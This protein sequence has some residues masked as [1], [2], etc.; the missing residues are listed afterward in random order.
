MNRLKKNSFACFS[1]LALMTISLGSQAATTCA[2]RVSNAP[3]FSALS[4]AMLLIRYAR[5][6]R[7]TALIGGTNATD[8]GAVESLIASRRLSL[9][10]NGDTAFDSVDALAI[11][12]SLLSFL[13]GPPLPNGCESGGQIT[14][15]VKVIGLPR[16]AGQVWLA[17]DNS[18]SLNT[19]KQTRG[20]V[21]V[22]GVASIPVGEFATALLSNGTRLVAIVESPNAEAARIEGRPTRGLSLATSR[23]DMSLVSPLTNLIDAIRT[24]G[25]NTLVG[26]ETQV[27]N[28]FGLSTGDLYASTPTAGALR[29]INL[30][31]AAYAGYQDASEVVFD[32]RGRSARIARE[33]AT[34]RIISSLPS[35]H[36][37]FAAVANT[38][39]DAQA[40][41]TE[42]GFF[43]STAEIADAI[44]SQL[45]ALPES[46]AVASLKTATTATDPYCPESDTGVSYRDLGKMIFGSD[47]YRVGLNEDKLGVNQLFAGSCTAD[48]NMDSNI[49]GGLGGWHT[50]IDYQVL[51]ATDSNDVRRAVP[52]FSVV[53]GTVVYISPANPA[54][55]T[56]NY[57]V[58][59]IRD[60]RN[61]QRIWRHLHLDRIDVALNDTVTIGC[62]IG[63]SGGTGSVRNSFPVHAHIEVQEG[64]N[65]TGSGI[66]NYQD[67]RDNVITLGFR[68]PRM[69]VDAFIEPTQT[70]CNDTPPV[71]NWRYAGSIGAD[72][73]RLIRAVGFNSRGNIYVANDLSVVSTHSPSSFGKIAADIT[74]VESDF[75]VSGYVPG[76]RTTANSGSKLILGANGARQI[77]ILDLDERKVI[78]R[79]PFAAA[80]MGRTRLTRD[81]AAFPEVATLSAAGDS[82]AIGMGGTW[83]AD[84]ASTIEMFSFPEGVA[85]SRYV[86]VAG[87]S[88]ATLYAYT[89]RVRL[90]G[91]ITLRCS[92]N[93]LLYVNDTT[94]SAYAFATLPTQASITRMAVSKNGDKVLV[95]TDNSVRQ[96]T[97][98][99]LADT[100]LGRPTVSSQID[101]GGQFQTPLYPRF[102][103][104]EQRIYVQRYQ[105]FQIYSPTG[106]LGQTIPYPAGVVGTPSTPSAVMTFNASA[107]RLLVPLSSRVLV[108]RLEP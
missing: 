95:A 49:L 84:G 42:N 44:V 18:M 89:N 40:I 26:A 70:R 94:L 38:Y 27:R 92:N 9:D 34:S 15:E 61:S 74:P 13:G 24:T 31:A 11:S 103:D 90:S 66:S 1:A 5:G 7:G 48:R 98:F 47:N 33:L 29:T 25:T 82:L 21:E 87:G 71:L 19:A 45:E 107:T 57:G 32:T 101:F 4:D 20:L 85:K 68:N 52:Q 86:T 75:G 79:I 3:S 58:V 64:A 50:G 65:V 81:R 108:Y 59:A 78:D 36:T 99:N 102:D 14:A 10:T 22:S 80:Q 55:G 41:L 53:A 69:L 6:V 37:Q 105:D 72:A 17:T 8:A 30:I 100:G 96:I 88:C 73:N 23:V 93:E 83:T 16:Y 62:Q 104:S 39:D 56:K 46:A 54:G 97:L 28:L 91:F 43:P 63:L 60:S 76:L 51:A 2:W 35:L 12:R 67:Q 77:P 106:V